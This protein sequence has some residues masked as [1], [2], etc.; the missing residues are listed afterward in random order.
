MNTKT[1]LPP[2]TRIPRNRR[3][4][5]AREIPEEKMLEWGAK[6]FVLMNLSWQY[7]ET[8]CDIVVQLRQPE[9]KPLVRAVR[10]LKL[11]YDRYRA[12][13]LDRKFVDRETA[14]AETFEE[15]Y[16]KVFR[17]LYYGID[18][19]VSKLGVDPK[20]KP[21][22]IA[23][24]QALTLM[25]SVKAYSRICER[26]ILRRYSIKA[27]EGCFMQKHF[28]LLFTMVPQFA[29][30]CYQ[31]DMQARKISANAIAERMN[32]SIIKIDLT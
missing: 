10:E 25:D 30:D 15:R 26:E 7:V 11:E 13:A 28:K 12:K 5:L 8:I 6:I 21:L 22:V 24:Q 18:F 9:T 31:P 4:E 14:I 2:L 27:D 23:T 17:S 19:E 3:V 29:G 20:H 32:E 1:P 16:S